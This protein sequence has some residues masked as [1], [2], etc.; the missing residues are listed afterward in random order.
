MFLDL[1][2]ICWT[3]LKPLST[4]AFDLISRNTLWE[5]LKLTTIDKRLLYL[6]QK[7]YANS[8]L[9][10]R[11]NPRGTLSSLS[12]RNHL[13]RSTPSKSVLRVEIRL[14]LQ[15]QQ[16]AKQHA[17]H[18]SRPPYLTMMVTAGNSIHRTAAHGCYSDHGLHQAWPLLQPI[19]AAKAAG[20]QTTHPMHLT[21]HAGLPKGTVAAAIHIFLLLFH[22]DPCGPVWWLK[23]TFQKSYRSCRG[24]LMQC[25]DAALEQTSVFP[26]KD[27]KT[28]GSEAMEE[29]FFDV[30]LCVF[31]L[32]E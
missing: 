6:I 4:K 31:S 27:C 17:P 25:S 22:P 9:K 28:G 24:L 11:C 26:A 1:E 23:L 3:A 2:R 16:E 20:G 5:K 12:N 15:K 14:W 21:A 30:R 18:T 7:L 10:V 19:A 29:A 32:K 8:T 13:S